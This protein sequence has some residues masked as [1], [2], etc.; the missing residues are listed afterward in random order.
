MGIEIAEKNIA[1]L[2]NGIVQCE[3][4]SEPFRI[5]R[6][7]LRFYS[8]HDLPIPRKHPQIRYNKRIERM[9]PRTLNP[10]SCSE[11]GVKIQ[12]TYLP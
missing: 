2:T 12:T 8:I 9:N 11:C 6:E 10:D 3:E 4:T 7:E 5:L 1:H